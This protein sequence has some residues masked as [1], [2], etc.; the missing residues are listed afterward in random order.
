MIICRP[1]FNTKQSEIILN[2][3]VNNY[4]FLS[5]IVHALIPFLCVN[6]Q[7][8]ENLKNCPE[9]FVALT[10]DICDKHVNKINIYY[11]NICDKS[12]R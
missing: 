3:K 4:F 12:L 5:L 8:L 11:G 2:D 9:E 10:Y 1:F 6:K 7:E